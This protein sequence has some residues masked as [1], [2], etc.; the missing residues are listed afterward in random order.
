M[1]DNTYEKTA[2]RIVD[3]FADGRITYDDWHNIALFVVTR[4]REDY[5]LNRIEHFSNS[6]IQYRQQIDFGRNDGYEQDV[7]F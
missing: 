4:G 1:L 3:L 2:K 6:V 7:L 5:L